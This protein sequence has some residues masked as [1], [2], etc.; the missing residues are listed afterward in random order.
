MNYGKLG[1]TD[2]EVSSV[3]MGC[4]A[5]VGDA[6]WGPQDES[7]A[8]DAIR[9]S[10][11]VGVNFFDTAEGYGAG[12]SEE[13]LAKGLGGRRDQAIIAT[14]ASGRN[15]SPD[16]LREACERSLKHLNTDRID[17]YQIHWPSRT[18]PLADTLGAMERLR[19]EGKIRA[20]GV[21]N[22]A[23]G[24]LSE[25]LSVSRVESNQL[26]YSLLWRAVEFEILPL[27][28]KNEIGVLCYSPLMQGLLTGKFSSADGVPEGRA[29]SRLFSRDRSLT[30][31]QEDGCEELVFDALS[32]LGKLA[33]DWGFSMGHLSLAW[34]LAQPG[35]ASVIVGARN[36]LQARENA[37]AA[38]VA[39]T[40]EQ[41]EQLNALTAQIKDHIGTNADMWQTESRMR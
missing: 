11:D 33:S 24:D 5:I 27:C 19:D 21:S 22:F 23:C 12:S 10:L 17:L 16:K 26:P 25:L 32:K 28:S 8:L 38:D 18:I 15:L 41:V 37:A 29:R 1:R 31:H 7:D 35:V 39:L 13:L 9:A 20:M 4:W 36:A 34:L 40:A 30:R 6:T 14:K 2:I 3:C